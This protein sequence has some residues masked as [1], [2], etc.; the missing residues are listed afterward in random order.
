MFGYFLQLFPY[1]IAGVLL[2]EALK[3][4]SW[5][6]L[7]YRSINSRPFPAV[8]IAAILGI[9]S[10][11]C[12][13]GTVPVLLTLYSAGI[14]VYPLISFLAASSMMNPQLFIMTGGGLG[15]DMAAARLICVFAFA[16]FIGLATMLIPE[17]FIVR[18]K[19]LTPDTAPIENR[20]KPPF[21]W[22]SYFKNSLGTLLFT[23]KM[24]F[25][26][27]L[28]ASLAELLP[29][30]LWMQQIDVSSPF[31][32]VIAAVAGIPL[33]ACGGG[34]IPMVSSLMAQG[35]P[36]GSAL[37]FLTAGPA[38]RVTSLAAIAVIFK[39]RYIALYTVLILLFSVAAG[40]YYGII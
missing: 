4:T 13:Y 21:T 1:V 24:M 22:K 32:V 2:G 37:A 38:T 8:F 40:I 16:I 34:T 14:S 31:S 27:I 19:L 9:I 18:E 10:P 33:Y 7:L 12:T 3:F 25:I 26:G 36:R 30:N 28:I 29:V 20:I 6:R 15:W 11:L 39:K 17:R 5:T 35:M 23:A